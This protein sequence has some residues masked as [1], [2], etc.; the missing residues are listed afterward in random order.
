[1]GTLQTLVGLV[2]LIYVLCMIVQFVQEGI[3]AL[4]QAKARTMEGVILKFMGENFLKPEQVKAEL[5]KRGLDSLAALEHFPKEDFRKLIDA[6]PFTDDQKKTL[7]QLSLTEA[8]FRDQAEAAY[9]ATMAKFQRLYARNNKIIAAAIGAIVVVGL[10]A[11]VF[12]IYEQLSADQIMSQAIAGTAGTLLNSNKPANPTNENQ[13]NSGSAGAN[14]Q[15]QAGAPHNPGTATSTQTTARAP[16]NAP[17]QQQ[18]APQGSSS[19][20]AHSPSENGQQ[21]GSTSNSSAAPSAQTVVDIYNKNRTEIQDKLKDYPILV[22][23]SVWKGDYP[24]GITSRKGV[25][26][27]LGLVFMITLVSLGAPFWNDVLKGLTGINN[28]LNT[29]AGKNAP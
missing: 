15:T 29:G 11:N 4:S 21:T 6:V 18:D 9:D 19:S 14:T 28:K 2:V 20:S 13:P 16:K 26:T 8:Q 17:S 24:D 23:W 25:Y 1:M 10:N 3:K 5:K 12:K 7:G 27:A 22:R